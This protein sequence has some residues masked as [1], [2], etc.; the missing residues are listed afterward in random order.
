M[1]GLRV[2]RQRGGLHRSKGAR[3][4]AAG[5]VHLFAHKLIADDL[6]AGERGSALL[7][8]AITLPL[9]VVFV[10]GIYDF[11]GAFNQKQKI[12]QAA[13]EAAILAG[14]QPT[15]DIQSSNANPASL[16]AVVTA[17]INSLG[18]NG[19]LPNAPCG[20]PTVS[21]PSGLTWTYTISGCNSA[22]T[23]SNDL[24]ITINR[25]CVCAAGP[26]CTATPPCASGPPVAVGTSVTVTY[27]YHWKFNSAIQLLF[28][29]AT[30]AAITQL[31]ESSM[32]HNQ[33]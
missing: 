32:V 17:V 16:Q 24:V 22:Y 33:L 21:P 4:A 1:T 10:V 26:A 27:P 7:E 25:G 18:A 9:L 11:S 2:T 14:A 8:F 3:R 6:F 31:T 12:E 29:G 5:F 15:S 19:V 30:Y 13:Q 20:A 28:P 23:S